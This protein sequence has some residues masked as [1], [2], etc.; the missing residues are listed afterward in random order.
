MPRRRPR[1]SGAQHSTMRQACATPSA[2]RTAGHGRTGAAQRGQRQLGVGSS[3]ATAPPPPTCNAAPARAC[4][5]A[6]LPPLL[7]AR[8][9]GRGQ[10]RHLAATGPAAP[11]P[12]SDTPLA[13]GRGRCCGV[14]L[15]DCGSRGRPPT[16]AAPASPTASAIAC[17]QHGVGSWH[18]AWKL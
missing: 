1:K 9:A 15:R 4:P 8:I 10:G 6:R 7:R 14:G 2:D 11:I 16:G 18:A 5:C 13:R 12:S 3:S 17:A